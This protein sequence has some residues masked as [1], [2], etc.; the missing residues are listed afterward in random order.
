MRDLALHHRLWNHADHLAARV[1]RRVREHAH[2]AHLRAAVDQPDTP[3]G[4]QAPEACRMLTIESVYSWTRSTEYA[5]AHAILPALRRTSR[6]R[7]TSLPRHG[8]PEDL[9]C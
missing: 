1:E 7:S 4:Q 2:R 5:D 6:P 8:L 9:R 3:C